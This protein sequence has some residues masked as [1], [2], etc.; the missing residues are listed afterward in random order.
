MVQSRLLYRH[1]ARKRR[2]AAL[3]LEEKQEQKHGAIPAKKRLL[4]GVARGCLPAVAPPSSFSFF[5]PL[6]GARRRE[7]RV[8]QGLPKPQPRS[9]GELHGV[10]LLS[11]L[12]RSSPRPPPP[13]PSCTVLVVNA[14]QGKGSCRRGLLLL[15]QA[16]QRPL[17]AGEEHRRRGLHNPES[18]GI[19]GDSHSFIYQQHSE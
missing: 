9:A 16:T 4:N 6:T 12:A 3:I 19:K 15:H 14:G 18:L 10:Y 2:T 17:P 8:C 1:K 11:V 13:P 7:R 5:S